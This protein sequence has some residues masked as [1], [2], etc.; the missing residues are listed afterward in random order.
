MGKKEADNF[1]SIFPR[2]DVFISI[3]S[4][5]L[6]AR[7]WERFHF[8]LPHDLLLFLSR[9]GA[10]YFADRELYIFGNQ[11][12]SLYR[13]SLLDWNSRPFWGEIFP[14]PDRGGPIFF[15]E[16]CFGDQLGIIR[17]SRFAP[18]ILFLVDS[19]LT[20]LL[21]KDLAGFCDKVLTSRFALLDY[22][23]LKGVS[24][25][26]GPPR[27]NV[28]FAPTL[29]PFHGG[30]LVPQNFMCVKPELHLLNAVSLLVARSN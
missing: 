24:S 11:G 23:L 29:S 3:D 21:A 27:A 28:H 9:Q 25:R 8:K 19:G 30:V 26:L 20:L 14:A 12:D 18:V 7:V 15:A 6:Y 1:P 13:E 16:T 4:E 17:R 10:G 5:R 2:D 22:N